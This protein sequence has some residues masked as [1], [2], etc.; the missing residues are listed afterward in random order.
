MIGSLADVRVY[1]ACLTPQQLMTNF[2]AAASS[3]A[4][5]DLLYL[6]FLEDVN[7]APFDTY[8][9]WPAPLAD[10]SPLHNTNVLY[11]SNNGDHDNVW[12]N[13]PG[14]IV[15]SA[16]HWHGVDGSYAD[17]GDSN[18]FAFT[19]NSY[20]VS[21]WAEPDTGGG[22]FFS[23]GV[24]NTNGWYINE[25]ATYY[26]SMNTCSNGTTTSVGG[27]AVPVYNNA[28][29]NVV[30]S[31]ANG[32]NCTIFRDGLM[33]ASG[34]LALPA[35]PGTNTLV[36]GEQNVGP[37]FWNVLDG[38]MWLA[39][40]WSRNLSAADATVIYLNQLGGTPWP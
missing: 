34:L 3:V 29:H 1:A 40:I 27:G 30:V 33:A 6:K 39:Q 28:W 9:N 4:G 7:T 19:T 36:L 23:C 11:H 17:T 13:G 8:T 25:N 21:F 26:L 22:T 31:V 10:A 24:N 37:Y 14:G 5:P 16:L 12:I 20:S 18:H 35:P 2:L 32:T 38:N 15:D